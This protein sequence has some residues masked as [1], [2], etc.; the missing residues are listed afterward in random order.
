MKVPFT[1]IRMTSIEEEINPT[2]SA[3]CSSCS[4]LIEKVEALVSK[5]SALE[6]RLRKYEGEGSEV[7]DSAFFDKNV[8]TKWKEHV[9]EEIEDRTNRQL[10][11]TL[12]FRNIKEEENEKD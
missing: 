4:A 5:V 10:R 12:V 8:F 6:K 9:E 7:G 11:K 2:T 1:P 3:Q